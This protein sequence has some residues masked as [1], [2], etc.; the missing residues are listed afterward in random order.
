MEEEVSFS[1][2]ENS[3]I[4]SALTVLNATDDEYN[5]D[6]LA[7]MQASFGTDEARRRRFMLWLKHLAAGIVSATQ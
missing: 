5:S 4:A 7:D 2:A 1:P 6:N 3:A